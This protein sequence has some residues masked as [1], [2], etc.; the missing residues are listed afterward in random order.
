VRVFVTSTLSEDEIHLLG[1]D[2]ALA[3]LFWRD[4]PMMMAD[5]CAVVTAAAA[6]APRSRAVLFKHLI[7]FIFSRQPRGCEVLSY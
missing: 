1:N 4:G 5:L 6:A 7:A 2:D 3:G